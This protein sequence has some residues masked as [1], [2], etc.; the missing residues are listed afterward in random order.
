MNHDT[1]SAERDTLLSSIIDVLYSDLE[2]YCRL[3]L[4]LLN[5]YEWSFVFFF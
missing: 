1:T 4:S 2:E 5:L 3:V